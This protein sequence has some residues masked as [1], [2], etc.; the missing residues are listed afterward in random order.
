ML[1]ISSAICWNVSEKGCPGN[2]VLWIWVFFFSFLFLFCFVEMYLSSLNCESS[3]KFFSAEFSVEFISVVLLGRISV[4]DFHLILL[5]F[6]GKL[7]SRNEWR[8]PSAGSSFSCLYSSVPEFV[9]RVWIAVL[10][11]KRKSLFGAALSGIIS[12]FSTL[13]KSNAARVRLDFFLEIKVYIF[14]TT[15]KLQLYCIVNAYLFI[16]IYLLS[17]ICLFTISGLFFF[18]FL[19]LAFLF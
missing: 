7:H 13:A 3:L 17:V 18:L 10:D 5:L 19:E 6:L 9:L 8:N 2:K 4:V 15:E 16:F 1:Q 11:K 14:P 12:S